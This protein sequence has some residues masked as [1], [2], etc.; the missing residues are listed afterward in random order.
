[1]GQYN[2]QQNMNRDEFPNVSDDVLKKIIVGQDG[3]ES[4]RLTVE[5]GD[6]IGKAS[7]N[8]SS[9]QIRTVFTTIRAIEAEWSLNADPKD[10]ENA[11]RQFILLKSKLRYQ[12]IRDNKLNALV[13]LL[14]RGIDLVNGR[15]LDESR[16]QFQR[17]V[18]F[19]EAILAYHKV[20]GVKN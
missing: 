5:Y 10:A 17:F 9:S 13:D 8:V 4:A 20:A 6:K 11:F 7:K 15:T 3:I 1:M 14:N 12:A 19:F 16:E 18:D 2:R